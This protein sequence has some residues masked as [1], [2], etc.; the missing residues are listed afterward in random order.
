[1]R[2]R[3][4]SLVAARPHSPAVVVAP[5]QHVEVVVEGAHPGRHLLFL[6]AG[7]EADVLATGTV[8]RVMMISV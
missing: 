3:T 1:M 4:R 2:L 6:G 5:G 8:T 7:Q